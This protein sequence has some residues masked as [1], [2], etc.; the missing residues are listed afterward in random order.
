MKKFLPLIVFI[1]F[2]CKKVDNIIVD[3]E[4]RLSRKDLDKVKP[5]ARTVHKECIKYTKTY[6]GR[7]ELPKQHI[8]YI[9][10]QIPGFVNHL[11]VYQYQQ[12]HAGQ[13]LAIIEHPSY[14]DIKV[15]YLEAKTSFD[16]LKEEYFRQGELAM[17]Q[18][19]SIKRMNQ[20][21]RDYFNAESKLKALGI[22][23]KMLGI[24]PEMLSVDNLSPTAYLK[25]PAN[26]KIVNINIVEGSYYSNYDKLI[27]II[28]NEQV[29]FG[30][31]KI[32][33]N[34]FERLSIPDTLYITIKGEANST[35]KSTTYTTIN[36]INDN[37][38][39]LTV[40][41]VPG[42]DNIF[43]KKIITQIPYCDSHLKVPVKAVVWNKYIITE[44]GNSSYKIIP[45]NI[46]VKNDSVYYIDDDINLSDCKIVIE[47][48]KKLFT[49]INKSW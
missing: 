6:T 22:K 12:V 48:S 37:T 9:S 32:E 3:T 28:T 23:V 20:A 39:I 16:Y 2:A 21:K 15:A 29:V 14:L 18:A 7:T 38:V 42:L 10:L 25:S 5:V 1:L 24:E 8:R 33:E 19:T 35:L 30:K 26:G 40:N 27:A 46:L 34:E 45:V 13:V 4:I 49:K 44:T 47:N 36:N 17:D 11:K 41:I 43:D 31:F